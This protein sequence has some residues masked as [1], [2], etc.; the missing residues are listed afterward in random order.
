MQASAG[1]PLAGFGS[2]IVRDFDT[3]NVTW[4][5][6]ASYA[7]TDDIRFYASYST[8]FKTP[9]ASPD[10][11]SPA[12]C[13]LA[14]EEE[15]L[16]SI[17]A[18]LLT[19]FADGRGTFNATYF[20]NDYQD[21]QIN[22]TLPTGGFTRINAGK[23]RIQGVEVEA[24]IEPVSNLTIYDNAS[25]LDAE[26]RSLDFNQAG[27]LSGSATDSAGATCTNA[28]PEAADYQQQVIDC[29]LNLSLKN[30]PEFKALLGFNHDV[31]AGD[32]EIF[33]GADASWEDDS[34]GLVANP[35]GSLIEPGFRV[36]ARIRLT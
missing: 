17:E 16:D 15:S 9:G 32:G 13:F 36:D 20:F 18:G 22:G 35:P 2:D 19:R 1:G 7:F 4:T 23:A 30:A 33:L 14:V 3:D 34:F 5:A 28:D 8:G 31:S 25:W 27:L 29:A 6:K 10:C 11:F 24:S 12:A 26:Y 21:L